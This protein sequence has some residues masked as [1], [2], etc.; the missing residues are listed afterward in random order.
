MII[1]LWSVYDDAVCELHSTAVVN[2][3]GQKK[4]F[5][6]ISVLISQAVQ[7]YVLT[8]VLHVTSFNCTATFWI[9]THAHKKDKRKKN[10]C[11]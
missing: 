9:V 11:A 10:I 5:H 2:A 8:N 4:A 7:M 3:A 1:Y 6:S